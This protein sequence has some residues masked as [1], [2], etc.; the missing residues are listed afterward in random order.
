MEQIQG[1]LG[2]QIDSVGIESGV[3]LGGSKAQEEQGKEDSKGQHVDLAALFL[4]LT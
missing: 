3:A 4:P 2:S 1:T